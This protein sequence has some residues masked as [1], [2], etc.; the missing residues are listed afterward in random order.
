MRSYYCVTFNLMWAGPL[1]WNDRSNEENNSIHSLFVQWTKT[2]QSEIK[3]GWIYC[4]PASHL[5]EYLWRE[6]HR[7]STFNLCRAFTPKHHL[8]LTCVMNLK[9]KQTTFQILPTG[10]VSTFLSDC[11]SIDIQIMPLVTNA[12][13]CH[14]LQMNRSN[15]FSHEWKSNSFYFHPPIVWNIM[16]EHCRDKNS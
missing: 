5:S 11:R 15:L 9:L 7:W 2:S 1:R 8:A 13:K 16:L 3:M 10:L 14:S 6:S 12:R 4:R